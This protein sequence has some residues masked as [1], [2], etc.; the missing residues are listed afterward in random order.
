MK[1]IKGTAFAK[2]SFDLIGGGTIKEFSGRSMDS[3]RWLKL[4]N[5]VISFL[6]INELR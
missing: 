5:L 1:G 6:Y 4:Y 2:D 3:N